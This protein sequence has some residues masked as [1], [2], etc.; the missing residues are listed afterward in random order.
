VPKNKDEWA[1]MKEAWMK[2]L[3]EKV[4]RGWPSDEQPLDVKQVFS[5]E[6]QGVRLTAIEFT[7]QSSVRLRLYFAHHGPLSKA[8]ELRLNVYAP[9]AW[10]IQLSVLRAAFEK[11]LDDEPQTNRVDETVFTG[12]RDYLAERNV[13]VAYF[14]PRGCGTTSWDSTEKKL[15]HNR[16]RFMLLGQTLDGMRIWDTRRAMQALRTVSET[17]E[18]PI[19]VVPS[20]TDTLALYATL[21]E[22]PVHRLQLGLEEPQCDSVDLL[23]VLRCL[24]LPAAVVLAADHS[25]TTLSTTRPED[26]KYASDVR[27]KLEWDK[28]R[29]NISSPTDP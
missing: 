23:N 26:W 16:R 29:L 21:F 14:A 6:R 9:T 19:T 17:K 8:K 3:R 18:L 7:S 22:P 20:G 11:E 5:V 4:F 12:H 1:T 25:P 28:S 13:V 27:E 10:R 2:D 24:P 15:V